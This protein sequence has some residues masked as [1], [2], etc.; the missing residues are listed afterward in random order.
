MLRQISN[1]CVVVSG[2]KYQ[3]PNAFDG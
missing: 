3:E 1:R 2:I